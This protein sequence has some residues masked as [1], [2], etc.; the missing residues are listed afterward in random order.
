MR[1]SLMLLCFI[2][3]GGLAFADMIPPPPPDMG[4]ATGA[5]PASSHDAE[6]C[7]PSTCEKTDDCKKGQV[8]QPQGI[9]IIVTTHMSRNTQFYSRKEAGAA[10]SAKAACAAGACEVV[11]RCVPKGTKAST[12]PENPIPDVPLEDPFPP[13]SKDPKPPKTPPDPPKTPESQPKSTPTLNEPPTKVDMGR[14]SVSP[15]A[16]PSSS[17]VALAFAFSLLLAR[18]RTS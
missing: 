11:K 10:C 13:L 16:D 9:C 18:R 15:A 6:Y 8:C 4:C 17:M 1:A 12:D 2:L 7:Y 5:Y 14:C 3:P